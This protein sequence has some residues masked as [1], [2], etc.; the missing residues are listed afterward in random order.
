[1]TVWAL[2]VLE[3]DSEQHRVGFGTLVMAYLNPDLLSTDRHWR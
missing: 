1:M 3:R 2:L